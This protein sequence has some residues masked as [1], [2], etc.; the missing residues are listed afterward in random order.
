M[1]TKIQVGDIVRLNSG[2]PKMTV[3]AFSESGDYVITKWFLE[4]KFDEG[5]FHIQAVQRCD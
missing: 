3:L 2:G 5:S 4:N 1:A